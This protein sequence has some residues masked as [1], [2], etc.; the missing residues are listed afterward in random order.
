MKI[1]NLPNDLF[2]PSKSPNEDIIVHYYKGVVGTYKGR[3]ILHRNAI[4]LVIEGEKTMRFA[5]KTVHVNDN[6]FHFLS[7]QMFRAF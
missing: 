5:E 3:S 7:T 4:S 2:S 1:H 6:E